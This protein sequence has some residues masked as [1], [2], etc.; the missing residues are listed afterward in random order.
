MLARRDRD[1]P[2]A[3]GGWIFALA[4]LGILFLL[5]PIFITVIVSFND[6]R[7]FAFPPE[8]WS[9][10]WY[11]RFLGSRQWM[12][13]LWLSIEIA[14]ITAVLATGLGL[15]ASLALVRGHFGAK[16]A[17]LAFLLSP[18]IVPHI[19]IA[20]GLYFFF[21]R[22]DAHGSSL[23]IALGHTVLA[24]PVTVIILSATLQGIDSRL[25]HVAKSLGAS[26]FYTLRRITLPLI[27]PGLASSA[28]FAFL[29]SFDE[30]LIPLFLSNI[31]S[32][33]LSVR[34]WHSLEID[35]DPTLTAVS[36]VLIGVSAVILALHLVIKSRTARPA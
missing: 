28:L 34:I 23:A 29:T 32:Q 11:D 2:F 3:L 35:V 25:E 10:R 18:L 6:T 4:G 31:R 14:S 24:L 20:I 21:V 9:L 26:S 12:R 19:I 8:T 27:A 13:S 22:L 1:D 5:L 33:T 7:Y 30:L 15:M 16:A 17:I 36:S